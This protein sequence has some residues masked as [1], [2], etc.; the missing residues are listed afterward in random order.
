MFKDHIQHP[1]SLFS[2]KD[3]LSFGGL[4]RGCGLWLRHIR[5]GSLDSCRAEVFNGLGG[6]IS[7][8]GFFD[9]FDLE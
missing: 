3:F 7:V 6:P 5:R 8:K 1:V 9:V 2:V 4:N